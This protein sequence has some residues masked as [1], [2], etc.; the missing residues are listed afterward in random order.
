MRQIKLTKDATLISL[1]SLNYS[2]SLA[3]NQPASHRRAFLTPLHRRSLAPSHTLIVLWHPPKYL[4]NIFAITIQQIDPPEKRA[5]AQCYG[6]ARSRDRSD[7]HHCCHVCVYMYVCEKERGRKF[8]CT[9]VCVC[10]CVCVFETACTRLLWE[11][12]QYTGCRQ[13]RL[14]LLH[15]RPVLWHVAHREINMT[16]PP[17]PTPLKLNYWYSATK[18]S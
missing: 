18:S 16:L 15:W 4:F 12:M 6:N 5:F 14:R 10:M 17:P 7:L 2:S 11:F 8:A 3:L 1:C 13:P 9:C